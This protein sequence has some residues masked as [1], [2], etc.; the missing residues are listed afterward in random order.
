ML[1]AINEKNNIKLI[2]EE[3]G[4]GIG[5]YLYVFDIYSKVSKSDHLCDNLQQVYCIAEEDYGILQSD[6]KFILK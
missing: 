6:F 2:V 5:Y 1:E 3:A 4:E